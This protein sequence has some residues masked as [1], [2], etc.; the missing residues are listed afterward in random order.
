[1][2]KAQSDVQA[3]CRQLA[4]QD[5]VMA[6]LIAEHGICRMAPWQARPFDSLIN[7]VIGQQLSVKAADTI[8]AR[9]LA[10]AGHGGKYSLTKLLRLSE[11]ELR[12]CG[13][14]GAKA[15]Y[16]L[17]ISDAV[18]RKQIDLNALYTMSEADCIQALIGL[19]GVGKWTVEMLLIFVYGHADILSL[20]DWGLRRGAQAAY[21]LSEPPNDKVFNGMAEAWQPFRSLA[22]WYLWRAAESAAPVKKSAALN[23][24]AAEN[25]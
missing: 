4:K 14:S 22:S 13:L 6:A 1:M 10:K 11:D 7:A 23:S 8:E 25:H 12:T 21:Q 18:A 2:I 15:R 17:G 9:V 5:R 3:A 24:T 16:V 19:K 20:G